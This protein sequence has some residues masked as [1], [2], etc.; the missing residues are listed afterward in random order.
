M[1]VYHVDPNP[2]RVFYGTTMGILLLN[3]RIP[4]VPGDVGNAST[5]KF[6][7]LYRV[8]D[9]LLTDRL[10][11]D[12]DPALAVPIVREAR[13]LERG[14]VAAITSDCGYM[15]LFQKEVASAV[16]IPVFLSSWMQVPFIHRMLQPGKKVGAVVADSRYVR[17]EILVNAGIDES[18]PVVI[19]GM[20]DQPTFWSGIM[21]EEGTLDTDVVE[22]EVVGVARDLVHANPDIGALLLECSDLPPY[23]AAVQEVVRLPVFD[24]VS[25]VNYVYSA[26]VKARYQGTMY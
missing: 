25:M 14:G 20:Q 2:H 10:V 7:V 4:L 12:A 19:A 1:P 18:I 24:F 9:E 21:R 17:K 26:I 3:T 11:V 8:V 22:R 13:M 15:A 23:A 5:F 6:P 16:S